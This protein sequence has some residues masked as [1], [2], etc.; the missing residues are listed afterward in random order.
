MQKSQIPVNPFPGI[1]LHSP[2]FRLRDFVWR[3]HQFPEA[4]MTEL[5]A[6]TFLSRA[7]C[8]KLQN[9]LLERGD[10]RGQVVDGCPVQE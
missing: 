1:R 10:I 9:L 4:S 7:T 2:D 3:W 5:S 8:Y 6:V